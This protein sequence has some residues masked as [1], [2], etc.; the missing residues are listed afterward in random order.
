MK[1]ILDALILLMSIF[2]FMF[3]MYAD[4]SFSMLLPGMYAGI[5]RTL[6]GL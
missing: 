2:M 4:V 5:V 6:D 3:D 1:H